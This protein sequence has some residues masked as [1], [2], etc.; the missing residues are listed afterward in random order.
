MSNC[1]ETQS[2]GDIW[3]RAMAFMSPECLQ[4]KVRETIVPCHNPE[5]ATLEMESRLEQDLATWVPCFF[6]R[7]SLPVPKTSTVV[8]DS[9]SIQ[10]TMIDKEKNP[11]IHNCY[12]Q[13]RQVLVLG[14]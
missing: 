14:L 3:Q 1:F 9:M 10:E 7:S 8:H 13:Q 2:N 6:S 5:S 11:K 12:S 4:D